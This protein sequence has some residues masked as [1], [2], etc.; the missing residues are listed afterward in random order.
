VV[1]AIFP[2]AGIA[3]I[4][5]LLNTTPR[6][7]VA[8]AWLGGERDEAILEESFP[9]DC[10]ARTGRVHGADGLRRVLIRQCSPAACDAAPGDAATSVNGT[11]RVI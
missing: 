11:D 8:G 6:L 7:F 9:G 10:V 1:N 5:V 3:A 2:V 4:P